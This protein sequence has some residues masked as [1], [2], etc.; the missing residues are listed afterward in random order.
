MGK[1]HDACSEPLRCA[2]DCRPGLTNLDPLFPG[3]LSC[4]PAQ[5]P[6]SRH[7]HPLPG[8]QG[9]ISLIPAAHQAVQ[10][11]IASAVTLDPPHPLPLGL[12]RESMLCPSASTY[13][14]KLPCI[15][16]CI[17]QS[18]SSVQICLHVGRL[19]ARLQAKRVV[20]TALSLQHVLLRPSREVRLSNHRHLTFLQ[21]LDD[22]SLGV[23]T[24]DN[25][26]VAPVWGW[27]RHATRYG[28]SWTVCSQVLQAVPPMFPWIS[29]RSMAQKLLVR[30]K[31]LSRNL[32][33]GAERGGGGG[34]SI[35]SISSHASS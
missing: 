35:W 3:L 7:H 28:R 30:G 12:L 6:P 21:E 29:P 17:V 4:I 5:G 20:Y 8:L 16:P 27:L 15:V 22:P 13:M 14:T 31:R 19:L 18:R 26:Y 10:R 9:S 23:P 34:A 11:C 2:R 33:V 24:S 1:L 25:V 32:G